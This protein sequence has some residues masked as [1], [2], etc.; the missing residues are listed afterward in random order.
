SGA[1]AA[2]LGHSL[3]NRAAP[4]AGSAPVKSSSPLGAG[5][6]NTPAPAEGSSA[7]PSSAPLAPPVPAS[8]SR[9]SAPSSEPPPAAPTPP[10]AGRIKH[11]F[12]V[13]LASPGYEAAFGETS[14]MPYLATQLRPKGE[15]L[16]GYKLLD[17]AA[18]PNG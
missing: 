2:L 10:E 3:A 8:P 5:G 6:G 13:S 12:V 16:S 9:E 4:V 7:A 14:Q 17:A 15:L 1:L 18:V 11:V